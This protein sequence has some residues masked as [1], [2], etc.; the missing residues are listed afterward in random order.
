VLQR[1]ADKAAKAIGCRPFQKSS[2]LQCVAVRFSVLQR[3]AD[4]AAKAIG[5]RPFQKSTQT[6]SC[7]LNFRRDLSFENFLQIRPPR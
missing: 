3:V 4:K 6:H 7:P 2:L 5:C 1:V